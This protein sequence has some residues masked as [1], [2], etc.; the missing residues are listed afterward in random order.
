MAATPWLLLLCLA[1]AAASSAM[2]QARA[3]PDNKGFIS[4]DCG[5]PGETSY[6]DS[7]TELSYAPDAAFIDAGSNHNISV[8]YMKPQSLLSKR[9][10]DLRSFP[11]GPWWPGSTRNCY[12]LRSLVPGLKHLVRA[13]FFYGNYDGLNRMP[14]FDLHIGVNFWKTVNISGSGYVVQVEAFVVVPNDF[15]QICLINTGTG[16]PFISGLDLR[17]LKKTIYPQAT[18]TQGLV[19]LARLNFGPTDESIFVRYPDDPYDRIWT[20]RVDT[21][22]WTE[23]STTNRV[24]NINDDLF[25][26]PTAVMQTAIRPRGAS[27]HIEL[28]WDAEPQPSDP[29]PAYVAIMHLAELQVIPSNAVRQI[30]VILNGKPWYTSGFAPDYLSSGAA[31]TN[32]L[33]RQ[34]RYNLSIVSTTN[35]TL[36]PI[37]N[38][39]EIFSVIPTTNLSTASQDVSTIEAI[40]GKYQVKKNWM[41]DPCVPK[42]F[43]W[44]GLSC[45]YAISS[46]PAVIGLNLSSSGLSGNLSSSFASLKGLQYLDLSHNNITDSI[47]DALSQLFSLT[48]LD[49]TDNQLSGSIPPGLVKRTQDGSLT[50]RYGN[51]PNLCSNGNYCQLPKKKTS[52][53]VVV[54]VVVP[55]VTIIVILLLSVL[56]ICMRRRQGR[57]RGNIN[58]RDEANIKGHN[59]L[60]FDNRRFTYSELEAITNG[61]QRVIGRG[62]FGKVYHGSLEDGTQVAIKLRSESSDQ[63]EKEFLAEAQTLAKIHHK[64][65]VSLI[66]YYKDME[67]MALVYEYMSEGSLDEHLSGKDN[68]MRTL[69]WRQRLRIALESAQGL[70]YLHK[71]CNPPLVHRDIKTS[72]ILLNENLEAKIADFGLLK[73]FNSNT[74]T[75]VSTARVVGTLGYLD[76][77]YHATFHLTNKSDIFSFGIVLLEIVTGQRHILNDPE[78][79]SIA[80][81]VR[82]RLT[83]GNI[84]DVVDARMCGDHNVNSVWKVADTALKCTAQKAGQ[85]PTMNDIVVVL[86][87]CLELEVAH[88]NVNAVFYTTRSRRN[89]NGCGRYDIDTSTDESQ[90]NTTSELEH[91]GSI[92]TM[93]TG[94]AIR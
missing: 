77:E 76:P 26:A 89:I 91:F 78:P 11:G 3:Q 68:T 81:W 84:E 62:G 28:F 41:G 35:S 42:N 27:R 92:P 94:P 18:P 83:H 14:T 90:S 58:Q 22:T 64:N 23:I 31:Y 21:R 38:A 67:C 15:V 69:T 44:K 6:I 29:S 80:Q 30:N 66:G 4:I 12:T 24:Q 61:F 37:L 17:P 36:P 19:L 39:V 75:H 56:L 79:T 2:L 50:L 57:T 53:M 65:I 60:Q 43:A 45:S 46:P 32:N 87:E 54:Y 55:I 8:E 93:A 59:S 49:L 16:T 63:S 48:L 5:F 25:E 71:G 82:Q 40:R 72:N 34:S 70:E 51:N 52:S 10:H 1:A 9:Y 7:T 88:D 33:Y 74:D 85:R 73:A 86:Q 13:T 20:P 47:P